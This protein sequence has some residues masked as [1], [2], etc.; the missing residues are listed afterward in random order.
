MEFVIV[1]LIGLGGLYIISNQE[2]KSQTPSQTSKFN[3]ESFEN[4]PKDRN[5]GELLSNTNIPDANYPNDFLVTDLESNVT[6]KLSSMHKYDGAGHGVYTDK[7]FKNPIQEQGVITASTSLSPSNEYMS[8]TGQSVG[9]DYFRHNNM[10]PFFGSKSHQINQ[11]NATEST[12]DNYTGAGSQAISKKEQAPMFHP[13]DNYQWANG[14][15]NSTDFVQ[16]RMNPSTR[17]ANTQPFESIKVA[18]GLGLGYT[19]EGVGGFN[20]GVMARELWRDKTVDELRVA[21]KQK[22]SG[23]GLF[24]YEGPASSNVQEMGQIGRV[25]KNRVEKTFE[26]GQDRLFTTTGVE[27]GST[28]RPITV[29]RD[30]NRPDTT[31]SYIGNAGYNNGEHI[32]GEYMPSHNQSLGPLPIAPAYAMAS[33][34]SMGND[35]AMKSQKIFQN[36]RTTSNSD[37]YF[38]IVGGAVSAAVAP[39]LDVLRPSRKENTMGTLRPYQNAK[40]PVQGSYIFNSNDTLPTTNREMTENNPLHWNVNANQRGGAYEVTQHQESETYRSLTENFSYMGVAN[41]PS[42][43]RPYDSAYKQRNNDIKSSTIDGRMNMGNMS[44]LNTD[45]N[46][47]AKPKDDM[48]LNRRPA[49]GG[50]KFVEPPSP[51]QMGVVQGLNQ[52]LYQGQQLDRNNGDILSQLKKNPFVIPQQQVTVGYI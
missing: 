13:G 22:A 14:M 11:P 33:G 24:G 4:N 40:A 44:L 41:G 32:S 6:S 35:Y 47:T 3:T 20:S 50:M 36:N 9:M 19:S 42:E 52:Q 18:P 16:S 31:T 15:P 51:S 8:L 27:K 17:M 37:D 5:K 43:I 38:G 26:M 28:L 21:N 25:E 29:E 10:A 12:L 48:L 46:M 23:F 2:T 7:Y 34:T 1:P 49:D 30:V 45:I 39:L